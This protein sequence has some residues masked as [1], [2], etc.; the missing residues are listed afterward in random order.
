MLSPILFFVCLVGSLESGKGRED[1][2]SRSPAVIP[3]SKPSKTSKPALYPLQ[4]WGNCTN[5]RQGETFH[6]RLGNTVAV[7]I[8]LLDSIIYLD[9][10]HQF[11]QSKSEQPERTA[12]SCL[13][14]GLGSGT[15]ARPHL[16]FPATCPLPVPIFLPLALSPPGWLCSA[17]ATHHVLRPTVV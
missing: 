2:A 17:N 1:C 13:R 10:C 6:L 14:T 4:V 12:L 3:P 5:L 15:S 7:S 16:P 9:L 11:R 8:N